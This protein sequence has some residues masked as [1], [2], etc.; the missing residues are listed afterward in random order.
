MTFIYIIRHCFN[1][2][3]TVLIDSL[4]LLALNKLLGRC[5]RVQRS[6]L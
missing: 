3:I 2:N 1:R 6:K 4:D 5:C